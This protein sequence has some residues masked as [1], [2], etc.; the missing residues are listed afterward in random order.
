MERERKR[1]IKREKKT[2]WGC[3]QSLVWN[4]IDK[5]GEVKGWGTFLRLIRRNHG[6][7]ESIGDFH[8]TRKLEENCSYSIFSSFLSSL[9]LSFI[10]L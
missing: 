8:I 2:V 1:E 4:S 3:R 10:L 5:K 9:L 7:R 6:T